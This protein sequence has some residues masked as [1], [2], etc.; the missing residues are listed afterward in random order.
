[1]NMKKHLIALDLDGTLLTDD[2]IISEKT[3]QIIMKAKQEGHLVVIAT[4][5]PHHASIE[6]YD[7]L[8][9]DTPMVNFNGA[10]I[11]HPKDRKWEV[12][13]SPLPNRTAKKIIQTCYELGVDNIM[14]EV[15]DDIYLDRYDQEIIDI[16]FPKT[17][18]LKITIGSI[19]NELTDD[20]TSLLIYPK[21]EH[22]DDLRQHLDDNH[23]SVIEHR[24][25]GTPWK[26][27][28]IVR[29]GMN[30]AVGLQRIASY[31][32]IDQKHIIAFG[33]EDN[34]LEMIDYAGVGVAMNNAIPKLK[35]MADHVTKS[36]QEDGIGRFLNDYLHLKA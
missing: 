28:E 4:G 7:Q 3:K 31:Y 15:S 33:D 34:D 9:L 13:H 12:L 6:Y 19:K 36:N 10:L 17:S 24:K 11:H 20:P 26:V 30:K 14:A 35:D 16:F 32:N 23:A 18:E 5:R 8:E 22:I 25:W 27:I 2:K 1:M 29:K 21:D